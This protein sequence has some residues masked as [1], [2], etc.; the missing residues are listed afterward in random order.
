M[1]L[2]IEGRIGEL[3]PSAE[4]ARRL[5]GGPVGQ[6]RTTPRQVLPDG[7]SSKQALK[8]RTIANNPDVVKEVIAEAEEN[9]DIPKRSQTHVKGFKRPRMPFLPSHAF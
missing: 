1:L 4:E 7:I 5:S 3:L 6:P 9:E 8:A 2:A